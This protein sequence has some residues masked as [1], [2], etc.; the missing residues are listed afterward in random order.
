MIANELGVSKTTVSLALKG[1]PRISD[2]TKKKVEAAAKSQGYTKDPH[3]TRAFSIIR[4]GRSATHNV[5]GYLDTSKRS[6]NPGS[7]FADHVKRNLIESAENKG[8]SVSTFVVDENKMPHKRLKQIIESR[9]IQYLLVPAP[10]LIDDL[11]FDWEK[12]STIVLSTRPLKGRFNRVTTSNYQAISL[13]M[14]NLQAKGYRKP[15]FIIRSDIDK[16]QGSECSIAYSGLCKHLELDDSVPILFT[17]ENTSIS[18]YEKWYWKNQPDVI[19][20][21]SQTGTTQE[22][23]LSFSEILNRFDKPIQSAVGRCSLNA[24]PSIE[25]VSGIIRNEQE[26]GYS[27]IELMLSMIERNVMGLPNHPKILTILSDWY[28]GKTLPKK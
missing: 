26:I 14:K 24:N 22:G 25:P 6:Q 19:I 9:N 18:A 1:H 8:F 7:H 2:E 23:L 10:A 20:Q 15:G 13:L 16:I 3:L 4:K 17:H 11:P 5:I 28:E 27:A 21:N 12:L